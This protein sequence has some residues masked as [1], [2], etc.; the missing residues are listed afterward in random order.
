M[1]RDYGP[2]ST[3]MKCCLYVVNAHMDEV[4]VTIQCPSSDDTDV[5]IAGMARISRIVPGEGFAFY[6]TK[7]DDNSTKLIKKLLQK[8]GI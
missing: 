2:D 6:F 8:S 1:I 4:G 3:T 7:I 5:Q